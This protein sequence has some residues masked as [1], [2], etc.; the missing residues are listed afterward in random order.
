MEELPLGSA[1]AILI[2]DAIGAG[3][4][5][6]LDELHFE[7]SGIGDAI[8]CREGS[9]RMCRDV[10]DARIRVTSRHVLVG[11]QHVVVDC[12]READGRSGQ[13]RST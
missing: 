7:E 12:G 10:A 5:T 1:G 6:N 2:A 8:A 3:G 9:A 4:V 13:G 11:M